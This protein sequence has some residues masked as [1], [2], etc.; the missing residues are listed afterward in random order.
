MIYTILN[1]AKHFNMLDKSGFWFKIMNFYTQF[2]L[3]DNPILIILIIYTQKK[4][5]ILLCRG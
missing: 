3:K 2:P 5:M 1:N 4:V